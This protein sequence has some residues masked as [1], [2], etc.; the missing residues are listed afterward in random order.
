MKSW[1]STVSFFILSIIFGI[2][3]EY[4]YFIIIA[5]ILSKNAKPI[6]KYRKEG[7]IECLNIG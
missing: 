3:I 1:L 2:Q 6:I 7:G 4:K 5:H